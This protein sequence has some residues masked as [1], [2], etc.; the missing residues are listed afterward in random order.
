[1]DESQKAY[2]LSQGCTNHSNKGTT[3]RG[4][5]YIQTNLKKTVNVITDGYAED[6][7]RCNVGNP[8]DFFNQLSHVPHTSVSPIPLTTSLILESTEPGDT[9]MDIWNGV[10]NTMISSL[11]IGRRYIGIEIEDEYFEQSTFKAD[12]AEEFVGQ[13]DIM[14]QMSM[15]QKIKQ[16]A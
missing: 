5:Q 7:I 1:L 2:R 10:A 9:I 11:M 16:V 14:N 8:G 6:I 13:F 3:S 4:S 15:S 12:A